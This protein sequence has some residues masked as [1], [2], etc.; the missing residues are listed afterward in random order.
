MTRA[1]LTKMSVDY[2]AFPVVEIQVAVVKVCAS[3]E[4]LNLCQVERC[5]FL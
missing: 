4:F 1:R 2:A 5:L 3:E